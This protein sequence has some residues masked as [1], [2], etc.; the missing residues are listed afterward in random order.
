MK[1]LE[2]FDFKA[3]VKVTVI[4]DESDDEDSS[5]T[6]IKKEYTNEESSTR[7]SDVEENGCVSNI[8]IL[9]TNNKVKKENKT[10]YD[11]NA[12]LSEYI[13]FKTPKHAPN[14]STSDCNNPIKSNE[15]TR[16]NDNNDPKIRSS[17]KNDKISNDKIND[18][19]IVTSKSPEQSSVILNDNNKTS[20]KNDYGETDHLK[21]LLETVADNLL[22]IVEAYNYHLRLR[23]DNKTDR[24]TLDASLANFFRIKLHFF[25]LS[26]CTVL[27]LIMP[28]E[29]NE[30]F[31]VKFLHG[32]IKRAQSKKGINV[33]YQLI[34]DLYFE[35]ITWSKTKPEYINNL[36][37]QLQA[38]NNVQTQNDNNNT[39]L[40]YQLNNPP[41]PLTNTA[42]VYQN[43]N[44]FTGGVYT[45][46][47]KNY[48]PVTSMHTAPSSYEAQTKFPS[49]H[50]S[51]SPYYYNHAQS[52][53]DKAT[54]FSHT[55]PPTNVTGNMPN[56]TMYK[57]LT[58]ILNTNNNNNS[59]KRSGT[60]GKT[61]HPPKSS[62]TNPDP[63]QT[64]IFTTGPPERQ[65][66]MNVNQNE[67]NSNQVPT[68]FNFA[69]SNFI[70]TREFTNLKPL[71]LQLQ[72][73]NGSHDVGPH[74]YQRAPN[75]SKQ[76]QLPQIQHSNISNGFH[77][78][79]VNAIPPPNNT[80]SL[81]PPYQSG[82]WQN[83]IPT[84]AQQ[85]VS[86]K[87]PQPQFQ[88]EQAYVQNALESTRSVSTDS[89]FTS[90]LHFNNSTEE[91]VCNVF[92]LKIFNQGYGNP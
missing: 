64:C 90:P 12:D 34:H 51:F 61:K 4:L 49:H 80:V 23:S 7:I 73:Q 83:E 14:N 62:K 2:S 82:H 81:P 60:S 31:H 40:K 17:D 56:A 39:L 45:H 48:P 27:V 67:L 76:I 30:T 25:N 84:F 65:I 8:D 26:F 87:Q 35:L 41:Y 55:N 15:L 66:S 57:E 88:N 86:A 72:A 50:D 46:N 58:K 37:T 91:M 77:Q 42:E 75:S 33:P 1:Q 22:I 36:T 54:T 59:R 10:P 79:R 18:E 43:N 32:V 44:H 11:N 85:N 53:V 16:V 69:Y 28:Q 24:R 13:H 29:K 74:S 20:Q 38:K 5:I 21:S 52:E 19:S 89:G 9:V 6:N 63:H 78:S 68:N 70:A 92:S 3:P 71:P 47:N